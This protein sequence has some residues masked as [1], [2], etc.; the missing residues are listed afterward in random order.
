MYDL[1]TSRW[2]NIPDMPHPRVTMMSFIYQDNIYLCGGYTGE[3][4]RTNAIDY[5]SPREHK[6]YT[7]DYR[8]PTGLE[9][10]HVLSYSPNE[11]VIV[12]G[13]NMGGE[14]NSMLKVNLVRKDVSSLPPMIHGRVLSKIAYIPNQKLI[15]FGGAEV[16][17]A[18]EFQF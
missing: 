18:E 1:K 3:K 11:V 12:G 17:F 8:L 16:E 10:G 6:W 9:A 7:A 15:I 5:Y 13:K 4:K 14:L 2:V